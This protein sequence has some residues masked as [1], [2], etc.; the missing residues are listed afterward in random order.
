MVNTR[1]P[2]ARCKMAKNKVVNKTKRTNGEGNIFQRK[3]DGK[4]VGSITIGYDEKGRQKKKI[5]Y[6]KNQTDVAKKLSEISGRIKNNSYE[7]IE[8]KTFGELMCVWLKK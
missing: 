5:I 7:I 4:W 6:G 8:H 1:T 3:S 2:Q